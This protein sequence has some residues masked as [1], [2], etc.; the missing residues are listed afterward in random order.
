M[1]QGDAQFLLA[2]SLASNTYVHER[3]SIIH[4]DVHTHIYR[5]TYTCT[6]I[7]M[8]MICPHVRLYVDKFG[9]KPA[10]RC[11]ALACLE[12]SFD[13]CSSKSTRR[14]PADARLINAGVSQQGDAQ[15]L[16]ALSLASNAYVYERDGI[17]MATMTM[18]KMDPVMIGNNVCVQD[19][20]FHAC[21]D[22]SHGNAGCRSWSQRNVIS[23]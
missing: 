2:L 16:L 14:C 8:F 3:E 12:I 6:Y 10:G 22:G 15:F 20:C 5:Q 11:P 13:D 21:L 18:M 17:F 9:V 23:K 1:Q 7:E 4:I 19:C